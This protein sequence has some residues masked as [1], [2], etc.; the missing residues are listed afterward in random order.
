MSLFQ[1]LFHLSLMELL[2]TIFVNF[3]CS[4]FLNLDFF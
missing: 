2:L 4:P 3:D 1:V